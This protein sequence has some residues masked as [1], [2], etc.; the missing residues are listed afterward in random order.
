M[1]ILVVMLFVLFATPAH[2]QQKFPPQ[3]G[4][5]LLDYCGVLVTGADNPAT[6]TALSGDAFTEAMKKFAWCSG[7][8][9]AVHDAAILTEVNIFIISKLGVTLQGPDNKTKEYAF[10]A[11]RGV[12]IPEKVPLLQL[13]RVVVKWL[14]THPERLH[15]NLIGTLVKD[16]I[17]DAFPCTPITAQEPAKPQD[18]KPAAPKR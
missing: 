5:G 16:A 10:N 12:C 1:R 8:L 6:L 4:N 13:A 9:Q 18:A 11:L 2:A 15:E 14:Q 7:Y 17:N 3:D